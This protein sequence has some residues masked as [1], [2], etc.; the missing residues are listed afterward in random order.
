MGRRAPRARN[1]APLSTF[2]TIVLTVLATVSALA[3]LAGFLLRAWV[4]RRI[5]AAIAAGEAPEMSIAPS[6]HFEPLPSDARWQ[7]AGT[8]A[9]VA[10]FATL[11]Y[12]DARRYRVPEMAGME[13][14]FAIHADGTAAA[15]YDHAKVPT[16]FDVVRSATD[17]TSTYVTTTPFHDPSHTPPG[18]VAIAD[19]GLSPEQAVDWLR[20]LRATG[21]LLPAT[22]ENV[23]ALAAAS[24][25]RQIAHILTSKAP[26]G[27]QMRAVGERISAATGEEAPALDDESL[28]FAAE[29]HRH[30]R[31]RALGELILQSF[32]RT[33]P[34]SAGEWERMRNDVV[35]IHDRMSAEEREELLPDPEAAKPIGRVEHPVP[36]TIY[37]LPR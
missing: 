8:P 33:H 5:L 32:L 4:R 19:D 14:V 30:V 28:R 31:E 20:G 15:I 2:L 36:A 26:S 29:I 6:I 7:Q 27:E 34:F 11:G 9:V 10:R 21:P 25:E 37:W 12:G 3:L 16:F 22:A 24:Y 13:V 23:C 1:G 17:E 18:V 35:V